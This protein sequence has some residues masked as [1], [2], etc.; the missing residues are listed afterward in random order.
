MG[1]RASEERTDHKTTV[2]LFPSP[3]KHAVVRQELLTSGAEEL[4]QPFLTLIGASRIL[5]LLSMNHKCK[6]RK[7]ERWLLVWSRPVLVM[8]ICM[9]DWKCCAE[10]AS[11]YY[12]CLFRSV[13]FC[14]INALILRNKMSHGLVIKNYV[15]R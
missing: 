9:F 1:R 13:Y 5:F 11:H 10:I 2:T 7:S 14:E 15:T 4:N 6:F 3:G 8:Q 12:L